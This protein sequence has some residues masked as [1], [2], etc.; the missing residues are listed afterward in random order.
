MRSTGGKVDIGAVFSDMF[1]VYR[2]HAVTLIGAAALIFIVVGVIQALLYASGGLLLVLLAAAVSLVGV[3]LYTGFV[4]KLVDDVRDGRRDFTIGELFRGASH[5]VGGLIVNAIL[6]AI[7][8][9]IGFLLLIVPGLYLLT[10]WAV[11]APAIVLERESGVSAFGRSRELVKGRGWDVFGV[12]V[13]AFILTWVVNVVFN[14][15]GAGFGDGGQIVFST[16]GSI[17]VAPVSAL[18]AAILYFQLVEG[19][20]TATAPEPA[21]P[22]PSAA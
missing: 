13:L 7:A 11:T 16:I 9:V 15:I 18:V 6:K 22:P 10:V 8:V 4:V 12:I 14:A 3:T 17:I 1:E 5:A 20:A 19:E 21:A 2:G